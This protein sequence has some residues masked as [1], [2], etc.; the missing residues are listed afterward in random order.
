MLGM[1][2]AALRRQAGMS[3]GQLA[4]R[5]KISSSAVGMY[6]QNRREP[7]LDILQALSEIFGVSI[8]YLV[9]G[10]PVSEAERQMLNALLLDRVDAAERN[11]SGRSTRPL[12]RQELAVLLAAVLM[13]P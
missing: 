4:Q 5:L 10:R 3:Q 9:T 1:R 12:S 13:E 6:E 8:D 11:L 7:S 2:I